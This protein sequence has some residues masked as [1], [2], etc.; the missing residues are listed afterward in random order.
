MKKFISKLLWFVLLPLIVGLGCL[1]LIVMYGSKISSSSK[2]DPEIIRLYVGD[3]HIQKAI[4]DSIIPQ[5]LNL[6]SSSESFYFT[7]YKLVKILENNSSIREVYL[8]LS[9][10]NL[11]S[12]YNDY[13]DG[14]FSQIISPNY[15][16]FLPREER[17]KVIGWNQSKLIP[18]TKGLFRYGFKF[19]DFE[20]NNPLLSSYV[21]EFTNSEAVISSMDKRLKLQFDTNL[22]SDKFSQINISYLDKINDLCKLNDVE[23]FTISTPLHAYYESNIPDV[24][25]ISLNEIIGS[26]QLENID[27]SGSLSDNNCF[28]PDGDH[29]SAKGAKMISLELSR[30]L[31]NND[32]THGEMR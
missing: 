9:Y 15:Y 3:S 29:V 7:Y 5:S 13:I 4:D 26:M 20:D 12:Y 10:H 18:F 30:S 24:Y 22:V 25:K 6:A 28:I 17:I 11:S 1:L 32:S 19:L 21:N 16:C 23:L 14:E 8:G 31:L 27:L 2:I